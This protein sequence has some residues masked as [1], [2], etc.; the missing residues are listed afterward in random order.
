MM[1]VRSGAT[2]NSNHDF[3]LS[4]G[5]KLK[6]ISLL[7]E[8]DFQNEGVKM[9]WKVITEKIA[10]LVTNKKLGPSFLRLAFHDFGTFH[11]EFGKGA[12]GGS[13]RFLLPDGKSKD[14]L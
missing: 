3:K 2:D 6:G 10:D 14:S 1:K 4:D 5:L 8:T 7:F 11:R 13:V 9:N 12:G